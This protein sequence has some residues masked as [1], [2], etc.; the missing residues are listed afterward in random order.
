MVEVESSMVVPKR[1]RVIQVMSERDV[2]CGP[3]AGPRGRCGTGVGMGLSP[4]RGFHGYG[5]RSGCSRVSGRGAFTDAT[6]GFY[7][8]AR[9]REIG[10][11]LGGVYFML[12]YLVVSN[13]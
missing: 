2:V 10:L 13:D 9:G 7:G 4:G 8:S 12:C 1:P 3:P 5:K 6:E 11:G